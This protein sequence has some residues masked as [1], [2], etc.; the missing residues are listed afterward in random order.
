M[1]DTD[2]NALGKDYVAKARR[3]ELVQLA[4][5]QGVEPI[6]NLDSL[7]ADFWPEDE[8]VED[9]VRNVRERRRALRI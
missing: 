8:S 2:P 9:F 3:Q 7:K 1:S 4:A 5:E 6:A